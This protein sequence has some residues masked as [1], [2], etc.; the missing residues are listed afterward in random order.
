[1]S[2]AG[3][4]AA[5]L[6]PSERERASLVLGWC[7]EMAAT[8]VVGQHG[9]STTIHLTTLDVIDRGSHTFCSAHRLAAATRAATRNRSTGAG[10]SRGIREASIV[11]LARM[12]LCRGCRAKAEYLAQ[13]RE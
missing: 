9:Q 5:A 2:A 12:N 13:Q 10:L 1:M 4:G 3:R 6:S 7:A 8:P 11:E